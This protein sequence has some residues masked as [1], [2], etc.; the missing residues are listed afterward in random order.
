MSGE[1][2]VKKMPAEIKKMVANHGGPSA[3]TEKVK[4]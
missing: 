2:F 3:L 4:K 1:D